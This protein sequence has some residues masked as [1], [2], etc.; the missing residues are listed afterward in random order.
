MTPRQ[1]G[2]STFARGA[3]PA[4]LALLLSACATMSEPGPSP[5]AASPDAD[6]AEEF[7]EQG[8]FDRA[9]SAFLD[10]ARTRRGD[11][12]A[13]Y[14]LRAAEA[15]RERGD[16][17]GA[18]RALDDIKRRRLHGEEPLRLDLLEA[19]IALQQGD[20]ARARALLMI[21]EGI[22]ANL[23]LRAL[24]LR[25][26]AD[27]AAGDPFSS[28][29]TRAR[30]DRL[31]AGADREQN[32]QL[33]LDTLSKLDADT[34]KSRF[35]TLQPDDPLR[36]WVEQA[37]RKQ[38]RALARELP[39]PSL[40]VGTMRPGQD[41]ALEAE[42]YQPSRRVALLLPL[43]AQLAGV[44]NAIRDGFLSA[45]FADS[46]ERRPELRIYDAGKTPADAIA[47]YQ[48]A[49]ADGAD[50]VVGPL[51]RES[52]GQ[53]FHQPLTTR[54][55]ALNHPDTGEVPPAGSAEY[56]LLPETEGA[57]VAERLRERGIANA[58]VIVAEA[59]WAERAAR[60]FRAQFEA[61]GGI[62]VGET[63]LR[64]KE[65]NFSTAITQATAGL[66]GDGAVFVSMR[67]QQA[68]LLLPQLKIANVT[69]PVFA[70]SHIYSGDSNATL[71]R[72]LD[73][74]EFCDAPWLFGP[75][76]GKPER[77]QMSGQIAS[78]NG[79][80]ARLFAF[81]MDA[82]A[83]LPYVDWLIA[84]PESYLGGATGELTA[85][86]FGRVHRLVSWARFVNGMPQPAEGALN[87]IPMQ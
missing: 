25:A 62:V 52:V 55:L 30:L 83:L 50:R 84:H 57:Q 60:A 36:P 79:V 16:F 7:Y 66:G 21:D 67:P 85:D 53:L 41:G 81:G 74:V 26:R 48:K 63:R 33:L 18:A 72:D 15:M 58:S 86:N 28:A 22:P 20:P 51:Q 65:V 9:A 27:V 5:V 10:L 73:G 13:H 34:L 17:N 42:G 3:A 11:E 39:R 59:D 76:P 64:E 12:A 47:A 43:N 14:Q 4:L 35:D 69:A 37:L 78:A 75:L 56:G 61:A 8:D 80:G 38:G 45:Y 23:R 19:E 31:L 32:R 6:R 46:P 29:Q 24:E 49:V 82:Y 71:D 87:T 44:A 2:I 70:T 1:P 68:R 77:S 54:V 40:P